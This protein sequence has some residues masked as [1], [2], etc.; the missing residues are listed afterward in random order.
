MRI[1]APETPLVHLQQPPAA[2]AAPVEYHTV[3]S[4]PRKISLATSELHLGL[5][6]FTIWD[7]DIAPGPSPPV[8]P[9]LSPVRRTFSAPQQAAFPNR[10]AQVHSSEPM[11]PSRAGSKALQFLGTLDPAMKKFA[12]STPEGPKVK[13]RDHFRPLPR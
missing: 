5:G 9:H 7:G 2:D 10:S 1:P 8:T 4:P 11:T 12:T 3:S 13:K 6:R